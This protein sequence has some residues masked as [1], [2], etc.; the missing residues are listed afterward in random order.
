MSAAS[1]RPEAW[2]PLLAAIENLNEDERRYVLSTLD[3]RDREVE[4]LVQQRRNHGLSDDRPASANEGDTFFETDTSATYIW[5]NG[6]WRVKHLPWADYTP[7]IV[8][9]TNHTVTHARWTQHY[10]TITVSIY[11]QCNAG[12]AGNLWV[13]MPKQSSLKNF[14]H[15]G[16]PANAWDASTGTSYP[17]WCKFESSGYFTFRRYA[18]SGIVH[19]GAPF[20]WAI[21][22]VLGIASLTYEVDVW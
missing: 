12:Y 11:L 2:G 8:S 5:F 15:V 10:D 1:L 14:S 19:G 9:M 22:D 20:T 4:R 7:A 17:I 21:G 3:E 16:Q 13:G 6:A 18:G